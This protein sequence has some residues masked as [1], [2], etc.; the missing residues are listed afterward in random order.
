MGRAGT[1]RSYTDT[2]T[3]VYD[4]DGRRIAKT[5]GTTTTVYPNK[6]YEKTGSEGTSNYYL[7]DRLVAVKKG[8]V[9]EYIHQDHLGS[10][11]VSTDSTGVEKSTNKTYP[12][13][14]S[15]SSSGTLG[16]DKKFTGQRLDGTGLYFYNARYYDPEIGR[17]ISPDPVV[18]DIAVGRNISALTVSLAGEWARTDKSIDYGFM[19]DP[20]L[21][22]RYSYVSNN[23][24][25]YIDPEGT[26]FFSAVARFA[27]IIIPVIA[28]IPS[29]PLMHVVAVVVVV[30]A[31]VP[32]SGG[33]PNIMASRDHN[34]SDELARELNKTFGK[35]LTAH[36]W[37]R[38]VEKVKEEA[39]RE[40]SDHGRIDGATGDVYDSEGEKIGN[41]G[42][43]L[44]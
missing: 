19:L 24:L 41:V 30:V 25:K 8:S 20:Q 3:F 31:V 37:G 36:D 38:L 7:G 6:Y 32:M 28:F 10:T 12:F 17:F 11:S 26:S 44:P 2:T 23:P 22:N 15:R 5:A 9:L 39:L 40:P 34:I 33:N 27:P 14:A 18:A 13:G 35:N 16:T 42:D 21:L 1:V 43:E 4:G 29:P